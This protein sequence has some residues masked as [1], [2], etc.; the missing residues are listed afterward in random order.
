M[1]WFFGFQYIYD[2]TGVKL[3]KTVGSSVTE[4][5]GNY[6]YQGGTLQFFNQPEGYVTPKSGGGYDYVYQYKDHLGNVRLS[7]M[8]NGSTT[9]IVEES[10]Y[11]P[12]GLKHKGYNSAISA[13]GNSVAQKWKF[14]GKE[15][16]ESLGLETYDFGAR[17]YDPALGRWF[18]VDPKA[19]DIMQVDLT[20]YNYSWNNPTNINDPDGECPWCWG[21][22]IGFA[23]EYGSQVAE[24]LIAGK[25]LGDALTDVD[26][27]KILIATATGAATGGLSSIKVVG[28][29]A[30]IYKGV[31]VSSTAAGGNILKQ[32]VV[33][34]NKTVDPFEMAT[35]AV[36][37]NVE[38]PKVKLP[39]VS[40]ETIK[41][42]ERNLDRVERV[43]GDNPRPSRAE[44]VKESKKEVKDLKNKQETVK[45]TNE[46]GNAAKDAAVKE[47]AKKGLEKLSKDFQ[48]NNKM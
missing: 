5:A 47:V 32:G 23:V 11:Y 41:T 3:K 2:A 31:A 35:D 9:E 33:D 19:D 7:Y 13:N 8:D 36:L 20:P 26:G 17:N 40:D 1:S 42:A 16:D 46:V 15:L 10:N 48:F 43:A 34:E 28:A 37:E 6:V 18:V 14:G 30:K 22:V 12:F 29:A 45:K 27:G 38:L 44:A 24:N 4:Y 25:D 39:E 21:A